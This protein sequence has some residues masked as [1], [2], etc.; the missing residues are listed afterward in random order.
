[1]VTTKKFRVTLMRSFGP[2][3][4][5]SE[6]IAAK[7]YLS[8]KVPGMKYLRTTKTAKGYKFAAKSS[9]VHSFNAS[10][11]EIKVAVMRQSPKSKVSVT[12]VR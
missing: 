11:S 7:R 9:Y 8:S 3:R 2:F 6:V 5:T 1:M 12:L 4:T 10:A